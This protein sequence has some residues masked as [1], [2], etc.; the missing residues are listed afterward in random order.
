MPRSGAAC[1][2]PSLVELQ[3]PLPAQLGSVWVSDSHGHALLRQRS[4]HPEPRK[5]ESM[6]AFQASRRTQ[7][8]VAAL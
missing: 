5:W 2:P 8:V 3:G 1:P 4:A 6:W 7:E